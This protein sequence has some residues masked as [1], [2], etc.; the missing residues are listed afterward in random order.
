MLLVNQL[1]GFGESGGL[2]IPRPFTM[3]ADQYNNIIFGY[4]NDSGMQFGQIDQEPIPD[5]IMYGCYTIYWQG[6]QEV[7]AVYFCN[8]AGG[9]FGSFLELLLGKSLWV[10]GVNY[11][12]PNQDNDSEWEENET[13]GR[14]QAQGAWDAQSQPNGYPYFT[15]EQSFFIEIK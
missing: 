9:P 1:V 7:A 15:P 11:G 12:L 5:V 8:P 4:A 10:N 13:D 6:V 3:I 14:Y 2:A